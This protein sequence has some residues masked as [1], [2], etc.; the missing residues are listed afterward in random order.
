MGFQMAAIIIIGMYGGIKL[1]EFLGLKK[2]PIFTLLFSLLSVFAA[3]YFVIK[4]FLKK[5]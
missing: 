3:I 1:D 2:F 4:D 5:K